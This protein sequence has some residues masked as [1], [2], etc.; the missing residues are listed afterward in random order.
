M[1]S[2]SVRSFVVGLA[3]LVVA[4]CGSDG[5]ELAEVSGTVSVDG[6]PVPNAVLTFIPTGGTTSYGKTNSQGIYTLRF[7]DSKSGAMLGKHN[8]EI[9]VKR[10]SKDELTEMKAAGMD[11]GTEFVEIPQKYKAAGVLT[12]E[13]KRGQN[14]IDFSL[15]AK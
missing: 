7:T 6:K 12:A 10:Y 5:P 8:V 14:K 3:L 4:G 15:T 13:V 2:Y 11:V 1:S 9:E